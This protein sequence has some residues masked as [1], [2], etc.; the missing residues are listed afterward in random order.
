MQNQLSNQIKD[1]L[2][3]SNIFLPN[4][5]KA[6]L[7]AFKDEPIDTPANEFVEHEE[8]VDGFLDEEVCYEEENDDGGPSELAETIIL[9]LPSNIASSKLRPHLET[10]IST[11]RELWKG[12]ANDAL[13]G[14]QI[15]LANKSILLQNDV[16]NSKST[17]QS[18]RA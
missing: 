4:L 7:K 11:E 6:D 3:S 18:T 16:N 13:E 1:F 5:E 10:L 17:K 15:G 8:V 9:P 2:Y 14:F 12:Q